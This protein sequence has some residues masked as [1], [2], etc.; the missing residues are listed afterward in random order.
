MAKMCGTC[1]LLAFIFII[2]VGCIVVTGY[3]VVELD[4]SHFELIQVEYEYIAVLFYDS[5]EKGQKMK[6]EWSEGMNKI[7]PPLPEGCE[8]AMVR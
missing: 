4:S 6:Q 8:I 7:V 3:D 5:S 1:M 2:V